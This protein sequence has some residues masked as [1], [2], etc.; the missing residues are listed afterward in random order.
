MD[1]PVFGI[2]WG[3]YSFYLYST[4]TT[5]MDRNAH[6]IVLHFLAELGLVGL[7]LLLAALVCALPIKMKEEHTALYAILM[8][9]GVHSMLEFPYAYMQFLVVTALIL[10][11][12]RH[13]DN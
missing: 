9:Q 7:G 5:V 13:V 12:V 11:M 2:G 6:N 10:G 1:N 3:E 4:D 8:I